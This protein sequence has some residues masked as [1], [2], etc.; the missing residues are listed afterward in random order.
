MV[1]FRCSLSSKLN[2]YPMQNIGQQMEINIFSIFFSHHSNSSQTNDRS[3]H[4]EP[5]GDRLNVIWYLVAFG[6]CPLSIGPQAIVVVFVILLV[7]DC[8][9]ICLYLCKY[10]CL[11]I[12][13]ICPLHL[14]TCTPGGICNSIF[15]CI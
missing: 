10:I 6:I 4:F 3:V 13:G 12:F 11:N 5:T 15:I 1:I 8:I 2:W 9:C 7:F 14:P